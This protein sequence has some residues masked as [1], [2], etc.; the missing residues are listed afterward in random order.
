M[1]IILNGKPHSIDEDTS[2]EQ[3]INQ[4]GLADK[5]VAVEINLDIIPRSKHGS[6]ILNEND[7]VE[8]VHAIGGGVA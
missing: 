4:L 8:V 5:R 3:L 2:I 1:N 7:N 6:H